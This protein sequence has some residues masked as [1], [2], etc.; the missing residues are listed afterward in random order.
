MREEVTPSGPGE[1]RSC[2]ICWEPVEVG[3]TL[4]CKCAVS[5]CRRC[6]DRSLAVGLNSCGRARCPTC[7]CAVRVDFDTSNGEIIF[8]KEA[9]EEEN[10][11]MQIQE[12]AS[13]PV[14]DEAVE[15][16][17]L[18]LMVAA[19][20]AQ[21]RSLRNRIAGP[22]PTME[23]LVEQARPTQIRLLQQVGE[24]HPDLRATAA[25]ALRFS[26]A[27]ARAA[28]AE[29]CCSTAGRQLLEAQQ[30]AAER[31]LEDV[32]RVAAAAQKPPPCVCGG[33][34]MRVPYR[35]RLVRFMLMRMPNIAVTLHELEHLVDR[36]MARGEPCYFCD[37][38]GDSKAEG[39]VWT[40]ENG[41]NTVLHANAYDVC[42]RCFALCCAGGST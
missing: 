8:S 31:L 21:E 7:R 18:G 25:E 41:N 19:T 13:S 28:E 33:R 4:P 5:Y 10:D 42:E 34:L 27:A 23:R 14:R 11:A 6:W 22:R 37:L 29:Q 32:S 24:A 39:G 35:E 16:A 1:E 9:E 12:A 30:A 38:C 3:A 20:P 26:Q 2:V 40:C 36:N 17:A 15:M